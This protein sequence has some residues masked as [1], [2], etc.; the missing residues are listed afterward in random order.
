MQILPSQCAPRR[1][2]ILYFLFIGGSSTNWLQKPVGLTFEAFLI[3][4]IFIVLSIK[5]RWLRYA[6][7]K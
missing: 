1:C 2:G 3:T 7:A 4:L 6:P 5:P